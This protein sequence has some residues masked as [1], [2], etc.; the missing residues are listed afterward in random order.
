[1]A[2]NDLADPIYKLIWVKET[3]DSFL[4][5]MSADSE[6]NKPAKKHLS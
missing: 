6:S 4:N 2:K 3:F 1:M 5:V